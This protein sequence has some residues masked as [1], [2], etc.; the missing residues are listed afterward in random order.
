LSARNKSNVHQVDYLIIRRF[1]SANC[2][3]VIFTQ[4]KYWHKLLVLCTCVFSILMK[5]QITSKNV[6]F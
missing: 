4:N 3:T 2:R 1:L 6:L 5:S